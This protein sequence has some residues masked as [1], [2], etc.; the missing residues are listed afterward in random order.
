LQ[1]G[2]VLVFFTGLSNQ[3]SN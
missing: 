3:D 2:T 1:V